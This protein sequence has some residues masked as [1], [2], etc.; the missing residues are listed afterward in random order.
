MPFAQ[1]PL[2]HRFAIDKYVA[3]SGADKGEVV[4]EEAAAQPLGR[5]GQPEEVADL[6]CFLCSDKAAFITGS[7]YA[8]DGGYTAQ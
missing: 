3:K 7:L 8:V 5:L 2:K 1:A 6:V 4:A